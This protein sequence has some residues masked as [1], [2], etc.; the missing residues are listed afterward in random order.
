MAKI[1]FY[2]IPDNEKAII[3]QQIANTKNMMAFAVEKD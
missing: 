3:F 1:N 2:N